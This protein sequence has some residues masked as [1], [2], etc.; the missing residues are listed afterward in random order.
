MNILKG[1]FKPQQKTKESSLRVTNEGFSIESE[2]NNAYIGWL[3][4][5]KLTVYKMDLMAIDLVCLEVE[6][7]IGKTYIIHEELEGWTEVITEMNRILNLDSDWL[8]NVTLPPFQRNDT[9]IYQK[10]YKT[11]NQDL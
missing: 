8:T 10:V 2:I 9:I 3:D 1:L 7:K 11:H 6:V 5:N 4:I